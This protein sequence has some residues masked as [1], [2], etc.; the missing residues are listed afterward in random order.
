MG[1]SSPGPSGQRSSLPGNLTH[2]EAEVLRLLV[3]HPEWTNRQIARELQN[4]L[5]PGCHIS[6]GTVKKCL[7][8]IYSYLNVNCRTAAVARVLAAQVPASDPSSSNDVLSAGYYLIPSHRL[9]LQLL[10]EAP[11]Y[12]FSYRE[13]ALAVWGQEWVPR[14]W[15][16]DLVRDVRRATWP[17]HLIRSSWGEGYYLSSGHTAEA[18]LVEGQSSNV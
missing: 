9:F 10:A 13:I 7:T 3:R 14:R 8:R 15:I 2:R 16:Y 17:P 4:T 11:G 12:A 5:K 1:L 6:E 18:F